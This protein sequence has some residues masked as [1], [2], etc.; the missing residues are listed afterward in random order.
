[1]AKESAPGRTKTRLVPPLTYEEAASLNTVFLQDIADNIEAAG[2]QTP[3]AGYAAYG[4]PGSG[5]FFEQILPKRFYAFETWLPTFGQCLLHAIRSVLARGHLGAAVLNSDSPTLPPGLLAEMARALDQPGDRA[6]LGP[7][8]DGGYYVLGL[9]APHQRLFE[10]IDWSTSRV[11]EQTLARAQEIN[12]PVHVL[13]IWYDVDDAESLCAL[14][15]ELFA[16]KSFAE[17]GRDRGEAV[18]SR[19]LLERLFAK[20]NLAARI[21]FD[22]VTPDAA[23]AFDQMSSPTRI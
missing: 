21:G 5:H 12:L 11:A 4:P 14:C 22:R 6:V 16:G 19:A 10:D 20:N 9:K 2:L 3:I 23:A 18:H 7:S 8:S 13:P 1:M 15:G 17:I